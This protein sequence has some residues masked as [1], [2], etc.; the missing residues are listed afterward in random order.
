MVQ[1]KKRTFPERNFLP[2]D[3]KTSLGL[4]DNHSGLLL[5]QAQTAKNYGFQFQAV[6]LPNRKAP[7][8][9]P[10]FFVPLLAGLLLSVFQTA[11]QV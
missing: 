3:C 2:E 6:T 1:H 10:V 8:H 5:S 11:P 9:D 4:Y 7:G